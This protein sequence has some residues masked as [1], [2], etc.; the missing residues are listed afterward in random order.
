M[1]A[2]VHSIYTSVSGVTVEKRGGECVME[3]ELVL[4]C[5]LNPGEVVATWWNEG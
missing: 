4:I 3:A 5:S 2:H 1:Q